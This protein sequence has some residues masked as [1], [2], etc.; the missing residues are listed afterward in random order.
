[1]KFRTNL[2]ICGALLLTFA[3][4][5]ED[6]VK[7]QNAP[8]VQAQ[9]NPETKVSAPAPNLAVEKQGNKTEVQASVPVIEPKKDE[10]ASTVPV[11]KT[12]KE[13]VL[14]KEMTKEE[15][16]KSVEKTSA[17]PA[18]KCVVSLENFRGEDA[19]FDAKFILSL[20]AKHMAPNPYDHCRVQNNVRFK[21]GANMTMTE[22]YNLNKC[23]VM[24][25]FDIDASFEEQKKMIMNLAY[26]GALAVCY[27]KPEIAEKNNL[28]SVVRDDIASYIKI[29]T[30]AERLQYS[31]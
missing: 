18:V 23:T 17:A 1:M 16:Q 9:Q 13:V 29:L 21:S 8:E 19:S 30:S 27:E 15:V 3:C 28:K 4:K 2:T 26:S 31:K 11:A 20:R 5:K 7:Q 22:L 6:K 24:N 14:E 25:E 10:P 12:E